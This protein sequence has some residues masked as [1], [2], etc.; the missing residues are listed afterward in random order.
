MYGVLYSQSLVD[1]E[2]A[3]PFHVCFSNEYRIPWKCLNLSR[4]T[5]YSILSYLDRI[6]VT[7]IFVYIHIYQ[8]SFLVFR[9]N[10]DPFLRHSRTLTKYR[11]P[12]LCCSVARLTPCEEHN[13]EEPLLD[14]EQYRSTQKPQLQFLFPFRYDRPMSNSNYNAV[15]DV[16]H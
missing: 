9:P 3:R 8:S 5:I 4:T 10:G 15:S 16:L 2:I 7:F 6:H 12:R 13:H 11:E 14:W 1:F